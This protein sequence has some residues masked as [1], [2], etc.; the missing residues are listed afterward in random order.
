MRELSMREMGSIFGGEMGGGGAASGSGGGS[1]SGSDR[2]GG[3]NNGSSGGGNG[4]G[5]T[6]YAGTTPLGVPLVV[7]PQ[8]G[9][10]QQSTW[11]TVFKGLT[12]AQAQAIA[13]KDP[14]FSTEWNHDGQPSSNGSGRGTSGGR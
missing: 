6:Q 3:S 10:I 12:Y 5:G 1:S 9:Q 8:T 11:S 13:A 2:G 14:V 4:S 7:N